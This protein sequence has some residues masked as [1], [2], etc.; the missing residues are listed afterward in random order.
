MKKVKHLSVLLAVLLA[1]SLCVVGFAVNADEAS[2]TVT[3]FSNGTITEGDDGAFTLATEDF[4][5]FVSARAGAKNTTDYR[6]IVV[7]DIEKFVARYDIDFSLSFEKNG[8]VVK[9]ETRNV[10][11]NLDFYSSATAARNT[12]IAADGCLLFGLVVKE[13]PAGAWDTVTISLIDGDPFKTGKAEAADV[14]VD[15]FIPGQNVALPTTGIKPLTVDKD[16]IAFDIECWAANP[17]TDAF[18]GNA[19]ATKLGTPNANGN[20]ATLEFSLTEAAAVSYYTF[21]TGTDTL[22]KYPGRNPNTWVVYGKVGEEWVV[23]SDVTDPGMVDEWAT[24]YSYKIETPVECKD[25][26]IV[27]QTNTV[28]QLNE[29]VLY[30]SDEAVTAPTA[31]AL[32]GEAEVLRHHPQGLGYNADVA[33]IRTTLLND[34]GHFT[35]QSIAQLTAE[36][37]YAWIRDMTNGGDFVRYEATTIET[38]RDCDINFI[39]DGFS[40]AAGVQYEVHFYFM[41]GDAAKVPNALHV[42]YF[43]HTF[44]R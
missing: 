34:D 38:S 33:R 19:I 16:S 39:L 4:S 20:P 29:I 18:D 41:T 43:Y 5:A 6:I 1:I 17:S 35:N 13:V 11:T 8:E 3:P 27:F 42:I 23:L 2:D 22:S 28:F 12:Y 40:A 21:F 10:Y 36:G 25:Y 31:A 44:V 15:E 32:I 9:S 24:P 7:A 30:A 26:K 37:A 14:T